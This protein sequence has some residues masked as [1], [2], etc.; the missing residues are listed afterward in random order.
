MMS[1]KTN[2]L[3]WSSARKAAWRGGGERGREGEGRGGEGDGRGKGREEGKGRGGERGGNG[4]GEGEGEG[5]GGERGGN[6]EGEGRNKEDLQYSRHG[7]YRMSIYGIA[8][9]ATQQ[10]Q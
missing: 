10:L 3:D 8:L 7:K 9:A 1:Q 6:G 2:P 5:R 4:E